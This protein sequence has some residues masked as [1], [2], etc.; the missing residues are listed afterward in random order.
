MCSYYYN[1][2]GEYN[3]FANNQSSDTFALLQGA[4]GELTVTSNG[5]KHNGNNQKTSSKKE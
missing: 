4:R 3:I 2:V 1:V 5:N